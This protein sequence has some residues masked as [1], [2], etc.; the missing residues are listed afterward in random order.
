M[1]ARCERKLALGAQADNN[2]CLSWTYLGRHGP[3]SD[4]AAVACCRVVKQ[5]DRL[6][7]R[8]Q[9]HADDQASILGSEALL[10][11]RRK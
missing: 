4:L 3:S 7:E 8:F 2:R 6:D 9:R 10:V 5:A 11:A 1:K